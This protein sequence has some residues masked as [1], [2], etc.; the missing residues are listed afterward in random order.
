MVSSM[1]GNAMED[2]YYTEEVSVPRSSARSGAAA[3][4]GQ[5]S[6]DRTGERVEHPSTENR[7]RITPFSR[8][9]LT[10]VETTLPG[11][12]VSV[13]TLIWIMR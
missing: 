12:P 2:D 7:N 4:S 8:T 10:P 13:K 9:S 5:N 1:K 3:R 11:W 6:T